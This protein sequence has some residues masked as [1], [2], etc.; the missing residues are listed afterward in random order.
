MIDDAGLTAGQ[1]DALEQLVG[2]LREHNALVV[3]GERL[4]MSTALAVIG[5]HRRNDPVNPLVGAT[6]GLAVCPS[7]ATGSSPLIADVFRA[8]GA[9]SEFFARRAGL[10]ASEQRVAPDAAAECFQDGQRIAGSI[11]K[12][13]ALPDLRIAQ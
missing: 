12:Q 13:H 7:S 6:L 3:A 11:M 1:I 8:M 10:V 2:K 4:E 5:L 9:G